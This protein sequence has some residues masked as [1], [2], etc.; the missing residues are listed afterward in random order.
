MTTTVPGRA[1]PRPPQRA[2]RA[3]PQLICFHEVNGGGH[4]AAWEQPQVFAEELRAAF[5]PLHP[6]RTSS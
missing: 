5:R 6:Q 2:E 4:L 3:H 1:V